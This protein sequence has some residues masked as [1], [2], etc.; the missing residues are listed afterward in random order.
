MSCNIAKGLKRENKNGYFD[1]CHCASPYTPR[2]EEKYYPI[3]AGNEKKSKVKTIFKV[4]VEY[5][6]VS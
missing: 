1:L 2:K 4:F 3:Y 5:S 6:T